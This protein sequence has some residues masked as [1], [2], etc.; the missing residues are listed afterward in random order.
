M[1]P[2]ASEEIRT[3]VNDIH[4]G[5]AIETL[6]EMPES[7]VHCVLTSP[8]YFGL[9]DYGVDGQIG[10]ERS[11]GEFV[12]T[13]VEVGEAVRYVLR[14]DGNWWLN[15]GDTFA[16]GGGIAGKPDDHDDLHNDDTYPDDPPARNSR[17]KRKT[18]MFVP[19]RVAIALQ[20]DGWVSRQDV[21]W[22]KKNPMPSPVKDRFNVQK[23][24]VFH[25]TPKP[26]YWFDL[27][28]VREP[29]SDQTINEIKNAPTEKQQQAIGS[30]GAAP[31]RND[32][33][34]DSDISFGNSLASH[35]NGKNPGDI[36]EVSTEPFPDAHFAVMPSK[37]CVKPTLSS[38]PP[39]VCSACGTPYERIT[40]NVPM[41]EQDP[42]QITRPQ[43]KRALE[44]AEDAG[45]TDKHFEA[46][47]TVGIGNLDGSEG[48]PYDRVDDET[49]SL[50][51]EA[52]DVL[53]SYY[54]EALMSTV[55]ST[56][57]WRQT[58]D[59]ETDETEPGIVLDPFCGSG[60]TC[61]VAKRYNRR[62]VGVDLNPEYV[63]MAQKR[64]GITV[65]EPEHLL[66][67]EKGEVP[68][69]T[70]IDRGGEYNEC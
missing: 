49:A 31:E 15:L 27:D 2:T 42:E 13:M 44:L 60:T 10:L 17:L 16:G 50:A 7:S 68:L 62:F 70:F 51:R 52:E 54:R 25:L 11:V 65:D 69:S 33:P 24:Y 12:E 3:W 30:K 29:H 45:L 20:E 57:S 66:D 1:N 59:C 36:I 48:N 5:D 38:C 61:M 41:W 6:Y 39:N 55:E 63:A 26:N 47:R 9:R 34:D 4:C 28:S 56:N 35:P 19:H 21:V 18:K 64:V 22:A 8:P 37:L 14:D 53:G 43:T 67:A 40:E 23:E 46:A 58:C 32:T